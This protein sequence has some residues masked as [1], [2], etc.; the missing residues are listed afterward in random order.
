M[1]HLIGIGALL[2]YLVDSDDD[3][4][5]RLFCVVDRLDGLRHYA[6]VGGDHQ[7]G[8]VGDLRAARSHGRER[9]VAGSVQEGDGRAFQ[10]NG[11]RADVLR[12]AARLAARDVRL[13]DVVEKGRLA[14]VDVTHD[15]DHGRTGFEFRGVFVVDDEFRGKSVLESDLGFEFESDGMPFRDLADDEFRSGEVHALVDGLDDAQHEQ[16]L[17]YLRSRY[18]RLFAEDFDGHGIAGD[19]GV[20]DDRHLTAARRLGTRLEH[21][22][23]GLFVIKRHLGVVDDVTLLHQIA[24]AEFA[25]IVTALHRGLAAVL[26]LL[27]GGLAR[28][29]IGGRHH[30]ARSHTALTE[31]TSARLG[32]V[33]LRTRRSAARIAA[34]E[35]AGLYGPLRLG[36]GSGRDVYPSHLTVGE[37]L[38]LDRGIGGGE[39]LTLLLFGSFRGFLCLFLLLL[40]LGL[41]LGSGLRDGSRFL[42]GCGLGCGCLFFGRCLRGGFLRLFRLALFRFY[43]GSGL[44]DGFRLLFGDGLGCG[45][46]FFGRGLCGGFLRLFRKTLLFQPLCFF[47]RNE[48]GAAAP[49]RRDEGVGFGAFLRDAGD[50]LRELS[51]LVSADLFDGVLGDFL[52]RFAHSYLVRFMIAAARDASVTAIALTLSRCVASG[53]SSTSM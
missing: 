11:V 20:V 15:G 21:A 36:C 46:L 4:H 2:V 49:D 48:N 31:G 7:H 25:A 29:Y 3:G 40:F 12:Y 14:V 9:L 30:A 27:I 13:A 8:D 52:F 33:T 44:R 42:F 32:S 10:R 50:Q 23:S 16:G 53:R 6:V 39:D 24:F 26:A 47:L 45:L 35:D 5:F 34:L 18:A 1:Q 28:R 43:L 41:D 17:D 22:H 51:R 37:D 38:L 19:D